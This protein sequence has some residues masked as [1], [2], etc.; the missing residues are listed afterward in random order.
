MVTW[1]D[2]QHCPES[3]PLMAVPNLQPA[4]HSTQRSFFLRQNLSVEGQ[5]CQGSAMGAAQA[6]P[7]T[8]TFIKRQPKPA[9]IPN[10]RAQVR[11]LAISHVCVLSGVRFLAIS[12]IPFPL[13]CSLKVS[14][15]SCFHQSMTKCKIT[16]TVSELWNLLPP[17]ELFSIF[18]TFI[19]FYYT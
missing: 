9:L 14:F 6:A 10:L 12:H 19:Y 5:E 7:Q 17:L 8:C 2:L 13:L 3:P 16:S 15:L 1:L 4:Q 11:F 18:T